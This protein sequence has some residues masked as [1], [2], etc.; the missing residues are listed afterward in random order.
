LKTYST[1]NCE[2]SD[3]AAISLVKEAVNFREKGKRGITVSTEAPSDVIVL[4]NFTGSA[5]K[6][7]QY[8][9]ILGD[10]IYFFLQNPNSV[11]YTGSP[12]IGSNKC[13]DQDDNVAAPTGGNQ[14][15]MEDVPATNESSSSPGEW[16]C[17]QSPLSSVVFSH[18]WRAVEGVFL[19]RPGCVITLKGPFFIG[20]NL[21]L[22]RFG[23]M[24]ED[25][26]WFFLGDQSWK[27]DCGFCIP[28]DRSRKWDC[29]F[30]LGFCVLDIPRPVLK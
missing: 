6:E 11:T 30:G 21:D 19:L 28:R 24:A 29:G 23:E 17:F 15:L 18:P 1:I 26:F 27:W 2:G 12:A 20:K 22:G 14:I 10:K 9:G 8:I 5:G 16:V 4:Q 3:I 13:G 25:C 7:T